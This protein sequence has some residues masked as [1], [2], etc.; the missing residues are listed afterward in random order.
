[1][2]S[3]M[4]PLTV[5]TIVA[6]FGLVSVV[7]TVIVLFFK[8]ALEKLI[9]KAI[10]WQCATLVLLGVEVDWD[11]LKELYDKEVGGELK[12]YEA[13]EIIGHARRIL[14]LDGHLQNVGRQRIFRDITNTIPRGSGVDEEYGCA[15]FLAVPLLIGLIGLR[16]ALGTDP[17]T[18][19]SGAVYA[20]LV[21]VPGALC[22]LGDVISWVA[23]YRV[24]RKAKSFRKEYETTSTASSTGRIARNPET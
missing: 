7:L 18:W 2:R 15:V 5:Y 1:M 20:A 6:Y 23:A 17:V 21:V 19:S 24:L 22:L 11:R 10:A 16:S 14:E 4:G 9:N 12:N 13:L 8:R 3:M